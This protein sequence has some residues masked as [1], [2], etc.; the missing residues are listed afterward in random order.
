MRHEVGFRVSV[1]IRG[2]EDA[3]LNEAHTEI[4]QAMRDLGGNP[5][6]ENPNTAQAS[7][8]PGDA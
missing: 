3:Q 4:M 5:K 1:V 6:E 8:E 7:A 2:R